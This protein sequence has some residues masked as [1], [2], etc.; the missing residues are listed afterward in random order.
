[1][2]E[3]LIIIIFEKFYQNA[4]KKSEMWMYFDG[5]ANFYNIL[6]RYENRGTLQI[7]FHIGN[8]N[9]EAK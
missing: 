4:K 3:N 1:M 6:I 7:T 9:A 8:A 5:K 2:T